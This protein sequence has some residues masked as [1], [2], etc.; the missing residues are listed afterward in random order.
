M[1]F[2]QDELQAFNTILEQ[3]LA[4]HRRELERTFDQR[5]QV[6]GREF[7]R[8]L[9]AAQQEL[10]RNL[11][12]RL[13]EQ[14]HKLKDAFD[15]KLD[16][17]QERIAQAVVNEIG[18]RQPP[19]ED[20]VERALAAQLLAFEQLIN[21]RLAF[22]SADASGNYVDETRAGFGTIEVQTEIPWDELTDV[23]DKALDQ[24]LSSFKE[25]LQIMLK[26]MEQYLV[27]QIHALRGVLMHSP[28]RSYTGTLTNIQDVFASIEQLEH[29]IESMQVA[30]N[31]NN[32]LLSNRLYHHQQL[33]LE[34][35]HISRN[36]D[37]AARSPEPS[38]NGTTSP[39]PQPHKQESGSQKEE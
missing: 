20:S 15:H 33:P 14:E 35:A 11:P 34:R 16:A 38:S 7:E 5:L 2:T 24:R 9:N 32:A 19:F 31:A 29:I 3:K 8:R 1:S 4:V 17:Q 27:A 6:L 26:N 18:Q 21:Q 13:T 37:H 25:S 10:L 23:I 30:M 36:V 22:F 28:A 39:L 12:Q